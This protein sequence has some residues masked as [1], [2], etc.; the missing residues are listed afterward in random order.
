MP[1]YSTSPPFVIDLTGLEH[2]EYLSVSDGRIDAHTFR[3]LSQLRM[4]VLIECVY[5]HNS[6]DF[7]AHLPR[8]EYLE[9]ADDWD[10]RRERL[11]TRKLTYTPAH[12]FD[13][14]T[15]L[16]WLRVFYLDLVD[17]NN[18]NDRSSVLQ[19]YRTLLDRLV[20]FEI[21]THNLKQSCVDRLLDGV[22]STSL[23]KLSV[24]M[25]AD[26]GE[27][28]SLELK[29]PAWFAG[30]ASL[31]VLNLATN[32]IVEIEPRTFANLTNLKKLCLKWNNID[33]LSDEC[34]FGLSNLRTLN[35]S[36]NPI[37]EISHNAFT[38]VSQLEELN[39]KATDVSF[40][41]ESAWFRPLVHLKYLNLSDNFIA[42]LPAN[43][44]EH[45]ESLEEL[46]L[47]VNQ[48]RL[49]E[50]GASP[51]FVNLKRLKILDL[52][53]NQLDQIAPDAFANLVALEDLDL[54]S[55]H[56]NTV[57]ERW[58]EHSAAPLAYLDVSFNQIRWENFADKA[59]SV[60]ARVKTVNF[61]GN[62]TEIPLSRLDDT[63]KPHLDPRGLDV[64][65]Y[66]KNE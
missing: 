30:L 46:N 25:L 8:L 13:T 56:L 39:L 27:K 9:I 50:A 24:S 16:R 48:I 64:D 18:A 28:K 2:L 38:H 7:L 44:F 63:I 42:D 20:L 55:N 4:L 14:L 34:L 29:G 23:L 15:Q 45:L 37:I 21:T 32:N 52:S 10:M 6:L 40:N 60:L 65:V 3:G 19:L 33:F 31:Q 17:V 26:Q 61:F 35:L 22:R 12:F 66:Y 47:S 36:N 11:N 53:F 62:F 41:I 54:S 57:D 5:A 59:A 58:F 51:K 43:L 49:N 1:S